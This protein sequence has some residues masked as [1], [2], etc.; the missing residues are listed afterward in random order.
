MPVIGS[1]GA[2]SG[3]GFGYTGKSGPGFLCASGGTTYECGDYRIHKFTSPGTFEINSFAKGTPCSPNAID[4]MVI[5]GGG[6]GA[7]GKMSSSGGGA[8]GGGAGGFRASDGSN[9][10]CYPSRSPAA[11]SVTGP[12][13][14]ACTTS[15]PIIVGAGGG[16]N[17]SPGSGSPGN[18]SSFNSITSTGGGGV[19]W[20]TSGRPGGSGGG[21]HGGGNP[22]GS[23]NTPPTSPPQGRDG[24]STT[25]PSGNRGGGGGGGVGLEGQSDGS[26]CR[27]STGGAGSGQHSIAPPDFTPQYYAG[28]GGGGSYANYNPSFG[29]TPPPPPAGLTKPA[30]TGSC[31]GRPGGYAGGVFTTI[32]GSQGGGAGSGTANTGGGGGGGAGSAEPNP[33]HP[34]GGLGS[35]GGN[36][37]SGVVMIRY[38]FQ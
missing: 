20:D 2:G 24:G 19:E 37:G 21:A 32:Y 28:G 1:F 16:W 22:V 17:P 25:S 27:G 23:G 12:T 35:N 14:P 11:C 8:G 5:A 15:Y 34:P 31:G 18:D 30:G 29:P 3:K 9:T 26:T 36:G 6:A 7:S 10:G 13:L 33:S 38:K 4:Y